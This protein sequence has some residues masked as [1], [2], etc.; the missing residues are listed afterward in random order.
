MLRIL[1]I[2]LEKEKRTLFLHGVWQNNEK[3]CIHVKKANSSSAAV[4]FQKRE[5]AVNRK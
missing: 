5:I 4:R 2:T 3:T 1:F